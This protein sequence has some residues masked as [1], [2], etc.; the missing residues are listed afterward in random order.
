[1]AKNRILDTLFS[2]RAANA[3]A[4]SAKEIESWLTERVATALGMPVSRIDPREQF[5][6]FAL[7]SRTAISISGELEE[8]LGKEVPPTL[9]WDYANIETAA[10][11]LSGAQPVAAAPDREIPNL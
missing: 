7:D 1:V 3:R 9:V 11:F 4:R 10:A 2:R 8:W 5:A 6:D